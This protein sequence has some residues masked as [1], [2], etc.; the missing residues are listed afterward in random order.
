[1]VFGIK[2]RTRAWLRK[3]FWV[4]KWIVSKNSVNC[5]NLISPNIQVLKHGKGNFCASDFFFYQTE[6]D[7][8]TRSWY[9]SLIIQEMFLTFSG[10]KKTFVFFK[11]ELLCFIHH[12]VCTTARQPPLLSNFR[13]ISKR[14]ARPSISNGLYL[15]ESTNRAYLSKWSK[16]QPSSHK[17]K[18][19]HIGPLILYYRI[20]WPWKPFLKKQTNNNCRTW[21]GPAPAS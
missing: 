16:L 15:D 21:S 20:Q 10:I 14:I 4:L 17:T 3:L 13:K 6:A 8:N 1:M 2:P 9:I 7:Q 18:S 12:L 5:K 19:Q 11:D